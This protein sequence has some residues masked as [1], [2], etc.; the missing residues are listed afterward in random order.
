MKLHIISD[1]HL[2]FSTFEPPKTNA[3]V[4]VLAGDVGKVGNGIHWARRTFPDKPIIYVIGNHEFYGTQRAET[5]ARM[6]IDARAAGV[7]L[8]DDSEVIIDGETIA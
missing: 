7:H 4:I 5:V 8:L 3:D 1:I 2:E 6:H